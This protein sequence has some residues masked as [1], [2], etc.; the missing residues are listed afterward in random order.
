MTLLETAIALA[1]AGIAVFPLVPKAKHPISPRGV[2]DATTNIE[3]INTWWK[4]WP[5]ANI[6]MAMGKESGILGIDIDYKDGADPDFLKKIPPTIISVTAMG[7]HHAFFK[8][9][10][11]VKNALKL[12]KGVTVRSDGLY[13]V[14]AGSTYVFQEKDFKESGRFIPEGKASGEY[15]FYQNG[16]GSKFCLWDGEIAELPEWIINFSETVKKESEKKSYEPPKQIVQGE[17]Y[18][19]FFKF[20]CSL[21]AKGMD[22]DEI[23]AGLISLNERTTPRVS[24]EDIVGIVKKV[25]ETYQRGSGSFVQP[26]ISLAIETPNLEKVE[27]AKI[28]GVKDVIHDD[29]PDQIFSK[30]NGVRRLGTIENLKEMLRR[31]GIVVRY[32]VISKKEE[33]LIPGNSYTSDNAGNATLADITS[34]CIRVGIP[35]GELKGYLTKI[36]DSNLYNPVATW[37]ESKEWDGVSRLKDF[38]NTIKSTDDT[39]KE[40]LIFRWLI[41]CVAAVYEPNGVSAHGVLIFQGKQAMGKTSW[42]KKLAP[43]DLGVLADGLFLRPDDKDS[44]FLAASKWIVELGE[45]D[46]TFRKADIAQL[47][48]FLP[49]QMD[50]LRR[51]FAA[52]ESYYARRTVFCGSV[53]ELEFLKDTTGNRRFWTIECKE[54]DYTH[55][56]DMQQLWAEVR[57]FYKAGE[58]WVLSAEELGL[59]NEHNEQFL[60][61]DPVAEKV[62][63]SYDWNAAK[64]RWVR[65]HIIAAEIGINCATQRDAKSICDALRKYGK[66]KSR[67]VSGG[68]EFL[69]PPKKDAFSAVSVPA[70]Y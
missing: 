6:G 45:L 12:E 32:N 30:K 10:P 2:K 16:H 39:L 21:R 42:F 70:V 24:H 66:C 67:R 47:K 3:S 56:I 54:I 55:N 36:A 14:G 41:S 65:T 40:I 69:V 34:W 58:K 27:K 52:T 8:Y 5:D 25:C 46:A 48:A 4:K 43:I 26:N 38:C 64:T 49:K 31:L 15:K 20:A 37:I 29:Y 9:D 33:I 1:E 11:R 19:N 17:K 61:L 68:M 59:L 23:I 22:S 51:P 62:M 57:G 13:F 35:H 60:G 50:I 28:E 7:G 63:E 53:N 18:T 44:V